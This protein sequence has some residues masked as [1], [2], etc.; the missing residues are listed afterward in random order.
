MDKAP[1][2]QKKPCY[3][4]G[5]RLGEYLA[6]Y[7]RLS[8]IEIDYDDLRE[9][10]AAYPLLDAKGRD[11]LWRTVVYDPVRRG[12][13][14]RRLAGVYATMR[15]EGDFSAMEH[16]IV[17]RVDFCEFG[18]SQPFRIRIVNQFNDNYDHFYVK[19]ADASRL[20]GLELEHLLSPNRISYLVHHQTLVE[21]HIAGVPG[22]QFIS[23]YFAQPNLNKVRMAKEFV[24][25]NE[26]C[27]IRLLGD[28]RCY[29][30]VVDITPDFEDEQYRVRAIDFDQQTYEGALDVYLPHRYDNNQPVL[31]LCHRY[32]NPASI[33]Q[34]QLEERTLMARRYRMAQMRLKEVLDVMKEKLYSTEE[35][36]ARLAAE[37]NDFH[38]TDLFTGLRTMGDVLQTQLSVALAVPLRRSRHSQR[39]A[40]RAGR[41]G[42][43][44]DDD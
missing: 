10:S 7:D 20:F 32:L 37:L 5:R 31:Q 9:F 33:H 25:F 16:L 43:V 38:G 15:T 30:Y 27:T 12:D 17:E 3:P 24:K 2:Q 21:E 29:N 44:A 40:A 23:D 14:Y 41:K 13:L 19:R 39:E 34:Y 6:V 8:P 26:R 36:I 35:H 18:N 22:D 28:M 42:S 1:F 11:T 4:V